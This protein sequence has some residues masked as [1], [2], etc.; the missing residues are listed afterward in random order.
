MWVLKSQV[1]LEIGV[2][3]LEPKDLYLL[4]LCCFDFVFVLLLIKKIQRN[5][6]KTY[7]ATAQLTA[8]LE[9]ILFM[10]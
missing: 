4:F 8:T 10:V 2:D 9:P 5:K 6:G 3:S 7:V 1:E